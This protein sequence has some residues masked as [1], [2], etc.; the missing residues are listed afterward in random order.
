MV[1]VL[2]HTLLLFAVALV[3]PSCITTQASGPKPKPYPFEH[4]AV[5]KREWD[6]EE[7]ASYRRV[8]DG[9]EVL[10]CCTPCVKAFEI[11][12]EA[13]MGPIREYYGDTGEEG[14]SGEGGVES[15]DSRSQ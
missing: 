10:F 14:G 5:I 11:N 4:C 13:F 3:L 15:L 1:R 2:A 7:G 9:Y 12:P 8:Y 6:E